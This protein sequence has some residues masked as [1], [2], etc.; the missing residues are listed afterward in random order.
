M[1]NF[2]VRYFLIIFVVVV[3]GTIAWFRTLPVKAVIAPVTTTS[4]AATASAT[5][6]STMRHVART[7]DGT[8][9][10]FV[11]MGSNTTKCGSGGL[12]WLQ[13]IDSGTTWTCPSGGQLSSETTNT[14]N[15]SLK[16]ADVRVDDSN[17]IYVV[18]SAAAIHS[19]DSS[20][21]VM[22]R[23]ISYNGSSSWTV[24][25]AQTVLN[26]SAQSSDR[27]YG[28]ATLELEG[29]SRVWIASRYFNGTNYG[30][31]VYNS[32]SQDTG[33]T[34]TVSQATLDTEGTGSQYHYP[35][36]V[37][38]GS[39]IGVISNSVE[40]GSDFLF[41]YR[42]DATADLTSWTTGATISTTFLVRFP[43]FSAVG[44]SSGHIYLAASGTT[45]LFTYYDSTAV[46]PVWSGA[47]AGVAGVITLANGAGDAFISTATNG[48]DVWVMYGDTTN[49]SAS[50]PGNRKIAYKKGTNSS[51]NFTFDT[52]PTSVL[53][54]RG[55]FDKVW[56]FDADA[57]AELRFQD[58][59]TDAA[60][61]TAGDVAHS[62]STRIVK[63][64]G[65]IAY[66]GKS[67]QFDTIAWAL[68]GNGSG[69]TLIYEYCS[70]LN[71]DNTCQTWTNLNTY[72]VATTGTA[73]NASGYIAFTTPSD[74]KQSLVN[75]DSDSGYYYIRIRVTANLTTTSGPIGTQMTTIPFINWGGLANSS[76]GVYGLWTENATNATVHRVRYSTLLTHP[77]A[78][79]LPTNLGGHVSGLVTL[80]NTPELTFTLSDPEVGEE[81]RYQI[82]IDD[83]ADFSSPV[84]DYTSPL[85][86][87]G[88]RTF[89]V[90]QAAG[91]GGTYTTGAL[92]QTLDN[93]PYYWK[94]KAIDADSEESSYS[95]ANSGA[96]AFRV[97]TSTWPMA[98]A[99]PQRTSW[100]TATVSGSIATQWVKPIEPLVSQRVQVIGAEG[101]VYVATAKGLYAFD[102][103][104]GSEEWVYP[105]ELPLGHS[106]TYSDGV[107]YVGG[108][109]KR[110]HAVN[111]STGA[112]IWTY[113]ATGGFST[114]PVVANNM[115]YAGNRDGWFY[116]IYT[117]DTISHDPG[118]LAWRY[119]TGSQILQSAA[120]QA[121][122]DGSNNTDEGTLFFA[123]NDGYA[124]A[125]DAEDGTLVW[126]SVEKLPSNG[127]YSWWPVIY[128]DDASG[129]DYVVFTRTTFGSG[130][131][132]EENDYLFC[133]PG[134]RPV[135]C[136]HSDN[137]LTP[138]ATGSADGTWGAVAGTA[139]MDYNTNIHGITFANYFETFP[140]YRNL[141]FYKTATSS[142]VQAEHRFDIDNDGNFD[143]APVGWSGDGGTPAPPLV[144]GSDGL[145][146]FRTH[147][148]QGNFGSKTVTGW[149]F[150][151]AIV[152]LPYTTM[153]GQSANW[154]GDE[155]TGMTAAGTRIFWNHCCDRFV[156]ALDVSIP[157]TNFLGSFNPNRQ[158][159]YVTSP[160]LPFDPDNPPSNIGLPYDVS[161]VNNSYYKAAVPYFWDPLPDPARPAAF[162]N[163]ND[164]VGP[165]AYNGKLYTILG[166]A[167]VA[168]GQGG[169]GSSAPILTTAATQAA[170]ETSVATTVEDLEAILE[171]EVEEIIAA[172][173][174]K[175]SYFFSGG[176][177]TSNRM[178]N[179]DDY[180]NHYWHN[181][182]ETQVIL[183]RALPFL[184]S[185]LQTQVKTYLQNELVN[186]SPASY[187]H[188]GFVGGTQRDPYPYPP[189]ETAFS[190]FSILNLDKQDNSGTNFNNFWRF[191]PYNL[192]AVWKY[193]EEDLV[194]LSTIPAILSDWRT[195]KLK[196]PIEENY[197]GLFVGDDNEPENLVT[198][199]N[200]REFLGK[201]PLV[202]NAHIAGYKGYVELVELLGEEANPTYQYASYSAEL[203]K[204]LTWRKDDLTAYPNPEPYT[205][206]SECYYEALITYY[207]FAYMVPEL[208]DY[209]QTNA[210]T[211]SADLVQEY[212]DIAPYWMMAHNGETQAESAIQPYQQTY[213]LFQARAQVEGASFEELVKNL[214]TPIVPTGDLYYIDNVVATLE[215]GAGGQPDTG[216]PSISLTALSPDPNNDSTPT[217]NGTATD[218]LGTV[219]S[220]EFQ[221]DSTAGA[222][223]ACTASDGSFNSASEAFTCTAATLSDGSHTMN[224][225][226]TDS[227]GNTT[228]NGSVTTDTFTIDT[229]NPSLSLTPISPDPGTDT[230]PTVSGTA[231]DVANALTSIEFQV[232]ST[233]GS[234]TTCTADDGTIDETSET[235]TCT[236][237][238]L[239]D[240]SHTIYVRAT[241]NVNNT[242]VNVSDTFVV[243]TTAPTTPGTPST[244]TP[245]TDT[246]PTWSWT[247]STDATSGLATTPYTVQWSQTADFSGGVSS[248][249]STTNSFTHSISLAD[250]TWYFRVK[251]T[252]VAGNESG[253][254]SN[255]SVVIDTSSPEPTPTPSPTPTPVPSPTPTPSPSSTHTSEPSPNP[256]PSPPECNQTVPGS[257]PGLY[258]A[259]PRSATSIL[260]QFT[261]ANDPVDHYAVEYGTESGV[262]LWS[263]TNIGNG[264][265]RRYQVKS[266]SPNTTYFFRVRAGNG[267]ATG[268][269]SNEISATTLENVALSQLII[270]DST[271]EPVLETNVEPETSCQ[272]YTVKSGDNLWGIANQL[273]GDGNKY[274]ELI[275]QNK[276]IYPALESSNNLELG[277]TL[278][279]NCGD[280]Q[281][282]S[283]DNG[284]QLDGY[285]INVRVVDEAGNPV[286]GAKVTI[287]SKVQEGITDSNGIATF[288]NVEPGAHR[289]IIA[290]EGFEGEQALTVEGD[291][292]QYDLNVTVR[293]E[294]IVFSPLAWV[295]I[296]IMGVIN[297]V[298]IFMLVRAKRASFG[299]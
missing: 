253:Y 239:S 144:S 171:N 155:P 288:N 84:V 74:W 81:V 117:D 183:L 221:M 11:Q 249:T 272:E 56:L 114:S 267:C 167:L 291:V 179:L 185:E 5:L 103:D 262:Y 65:D 208:A 136:S 147:T 224:V 78:P 112:G 138:G 129:E 168:I 50:L 283:S 186:Y 162:W 66:F 281:E 257:A 159:R 205:C 206:D 47:T 100:T 15:S 150:G 49:L 53:S 230:T 250:G 286:A 14:A 94:V 284:I 29:T 166:N 97:D 156:G 128:E 143:A 101:K 203:D 146:Y 252:D 130:H 165:S 164:K 28:Y 141:F 131:T 177:T 76:V 240:G 140:E 26:G 197:E 7:S 202:A 20:H 217:L 90:G 175:P 108:M 278:S 46:T 96:A 276:D 273:L 274:Q 193:A 158:W 296:A 132:S 122:D 200:V 211:A 255:G 258:S 118:D 39:S 270:T 30:V 115:V 236:A 10:S 212:R 133:Q 248:S 174:L 246:T 102:A 42:T 119:E 201:F 148:R 87:Q 163:E 55:V 88:S 181:P 173:H 219:T 93:G 73:L 244:T 154:P 299:V 33:P 213:S 298:L 254:S 285:E 264:D 232:D 233:A 160:G 17:N 187:A 188:I 226:A 280:K 80:D 209:L 82:Q 198:T 228:A 79:Y 12:W 223:T 24:N 238:A 71:G 6:A 184:S 182:A 43:S 116:A 40:S 37:R 41:K 251:A 153:S 110:I 229:N 98:G 194:N 77:A 95:T 126:K 196:V 190:S 111:A 27:A 263:A 235:F 237:S 292:K 75:T 67:E 35:T 241:D 260:L 83:S 54:Y 180:L 142:A 271:F 215:A 139:T 295:I 227:N 104:D 125:L 123:S 293:Q 72:Y 268:P 135:N 34:W 59:T 149:K 106:P 70:V 13:S 2:P 36:L 195:N 157:N 192:Y 178:R 294:P 222:W 170:D 151:T 3:L 21:D 45:N 266:L 172:G 4:N 99:N 207:N 8:L 121:E 261:A 91:L 1:S 220:V 189:T 107:L 18:Y 279:Y 191:P 245:T 269:W 210:A 23:K 51:G 275:D 57:S 25:T 290:Y 44:D 297:F 256:T 204:L 16:Y 105:T 120:Y 62:T 234:W 243:D 214:D 113:E 19:R 169:L 48:I 247:V 289:V 265:T 52:N 63:D 85:D 225:R 64:I 9:H 127:F 38:F 199:D 145:L 124:Y 22:Y 58:E 68:S 259:V 137:T 69:G 134:T 287:H 109:D 216:A 89:T 231:S 282:E 152:S 242:S 92:N 86:D 32:D 31:T 61:T 60:S 277:W 176:I 161:N 218:S